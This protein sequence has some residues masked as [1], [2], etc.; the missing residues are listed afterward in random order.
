M[1]AEISQVQSNLSKGLWDWGCSP[2]FS[3][4][5]PSTFSDMGGGGEVKLSKDCAVFI[6]G[7][8]SNIRILL[9]GENSRFVPKWQTSQYQNNSQN[10]KIKKSAPTAWSAN[11][12]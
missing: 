2:L 11:R 8:I 9:I 6:Y 4:S 3:L 7:I 10:V 5:F 1:P 12:P